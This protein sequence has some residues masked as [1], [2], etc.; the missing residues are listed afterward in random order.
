MLPLMAATAVILPTAADPA[1]TAL[2]I[3]CGLLIL[4]LASTALCVAAA[5]NIRSSL[6]R[7]YNS[8]EPIGLQISAPM[9]LFFQVLYLQY[10]FTRIARWKE[11][12]VLA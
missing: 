6:L 12:G 3:L 2:E 5:L 4:A 11:T 8:V 9:T 1:V 7:Y 10:H